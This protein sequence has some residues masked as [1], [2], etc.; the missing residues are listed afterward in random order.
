MA[1]RITYKPGG[2]LLTS[3]IGDIDIEVDGAYVDVALTAFGNIELLRERYY[4]HTGR[5]TLYDLGTLIEDD[6]RTSGKTAADYTL[7]VFTDTVNNKADSWVFHVLYC[8]R[9]TANADVSVFLKENF[10]TTLSVRRI[11]ANSTISLFFYAEKGESVAYTIAH[12]F[13]KYGSEAT[14]KHLFTMDAGKTASSAGVM[15]ITIDQSAIVADAA[16]FA[17]ARPSDIELLAFTV[18]CGQRS[19]SFFVDTS[20]EE[21]NSFYFRNCF[22]VWDWATL[23]M[24]TTAKTDV[25]RS[26]AIVNGSSRFYNQST[27]KIYEVEA[28]PLTSDEAEWIDQLFSSYDVFRIVQDATNSNDPLVMVPVLITESTCEMQDGDE[29]PN[30]VKF[31]W[32]YADNRPIIH[33]SASP[34]IF[35]SPF[36]PIYS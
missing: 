32:R 20:L 10:L 14:Y 30:S 3:A 12:T 21:H 7:R 1:H 35:T 8:D 25:D 17:T 36:N 15:Q 4:A 22:N 31:K 5:V 28:K 11:A 23:P 9:F 33:L 6:M 2:I 27:E 13:R 18:R 19:I 16:A 24:V 34:G 26:L 29:K